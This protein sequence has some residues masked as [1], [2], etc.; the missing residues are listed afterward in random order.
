M[1][2]LILGLGSIGQRHLRNLKKI[3][4][5]CNVFALRKKKLTPMLDNNNNMIIGDLKKKYSLTYI[6]NLND[7]KKKKLNIDAAFVCTP[8]SHHVNQVIWLIKNNINCFVEKPLGSSSKNLLKLKK[9]LLKK[10]NLITMM[11][12][13]LRFNPIIHYLKKTLQNSLIGRVYYV[14][15]HHGEH[16]NDFHPYENY[17]ISYAANKNLGGGV[18]LTQIHEIDYFLYLFKSYEIKKINSVS[19]KLSNLK[20]NVEDTFSSTFL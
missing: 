19:T 17:K 20:I 3:M 4:P 2:I 13:Q 5:R 6:N 14:N 1:N 8:S 10:K 12:F 16:I 11:G 9:L 15:I 7:I 18:L